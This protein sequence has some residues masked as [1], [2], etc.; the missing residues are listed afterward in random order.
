MYAK[1]EDQCKL[2][3]RVNS[4]K[5]VYR[6]VSKNQTVESHKVKE[7]GK[8]E[9]WRDRLRGLQSAQSSERFG[10]TREQAAL[11]GFFNWVDERGGRQ[12]ERN[13]AKKTTEEG[14]AGARGGF[15]T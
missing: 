4:V 6:L 12:G 3:S 7:T 14:R 8:L 5:E 2:E 1:M 11:V 15:K 10:P 13:T 9:N